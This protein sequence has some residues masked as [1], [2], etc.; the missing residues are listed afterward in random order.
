MRRGDK[1]QSARAETLAPQPDNITTGPINPF[2]DL[3]LTAEASLFQHQPPRFE[4]PPAQQPTV[5]TLSHNS[6]RMS[7]ILRL[8]QIKFCF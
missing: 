2:G 7:R 8:Y 3:S 5:L 6:V 1:E 4:A